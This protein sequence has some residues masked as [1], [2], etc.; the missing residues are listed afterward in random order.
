MLICIYCTGTLQYCQKKTSA[1][2]ALGQ[3]H[4]QK[5]ICSQMHLYKYKKA[6]FATTN[7]V[8]GWHGVMVSCEIVECLW[9]HS[10]SNP[11][12]IWV[13]FPVPPQARTWLHDGLNPFVSSF[14]SFGNFIPSA[15]LSFLDSLSFVT[16]LL[17]KST[18]KLDPARTPI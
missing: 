9:G 10:Y 14:I 11:L 16:L 1:C 18:Q 17:L 6:S 8:F 12:S 13:R 5:I 15:C 2:Q 3:E 4:C 7:Q